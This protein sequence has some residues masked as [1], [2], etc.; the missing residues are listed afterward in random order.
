MDAPQL[1]GHQES[2]DGAEQY[3]QNDRS[4]IGS[5]EENTILVVGRSKDW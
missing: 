1:Y 4:E 2:A 5:H 3:A